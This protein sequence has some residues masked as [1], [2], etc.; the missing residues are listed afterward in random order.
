MP[1]AGIAMEFLSLV[2]RVLF[3]SMF[4]ISAFKEDDGFG[5]PSAKALEPKFNLF[6][7]QV[8]TYT[9]MAVP[10]VQISTLMLITQYIRAFGGIMFIAYS[11][12]GAFLLLVFLV[13]IT[14]VMYDFYN[15]EMESPQFVQLFTQ[16]LQ[17]LALCGALMFFLGMKSS[18]PRTYP[19][20]RTAKTKTA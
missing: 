12:I 13:F 16:F 7:K 17:N 15:Y 9:G 20:R 1:P 6:V 5:S 19:K 3:A 4:L 2:G 11:S 14:P 10:H 18:I 8:S